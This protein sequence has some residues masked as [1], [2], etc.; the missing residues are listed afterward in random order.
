MNKTNGKFVISLDFELMWGMKDVTTLAAYGDCIKGVHTALPHLLTMF[1]EFEIRATFSTVGFLFFDDKKSLLENL[2]TILPQYDKEFLSPYGK[3]M[4]TVGENGSEDS[5]HFGKYLIEEIKKHPEQ[6]IGTH[7]FSHYY[8]LERGQSAEAFKADLAKAMEVG[9]KNGIKIQSLVFPK[10]QFNEEYLKICA[11][12]GIAC[13]RGNESSWLYAAADG[14]AKNNLLKRALRLI[15]AYINLSGHHCY[16]GE[17]LQKNRPMNIPSSRFLR[18][19]SKKLAFLDILKLQR[20][21]NS[22]THAAKNGLLYHLWWHPHNF[23][24]HQSENFAFLAKILQHYQFLH[25][26]YGFQSLTMIETAGFLSEYD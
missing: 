4:S 6:E 2:P 11:D 13:Y 19:F 22:M 3:Y 7:T 26:K 12:L 24:I 21:K 16:S 14:K 17:Y 8:C 25:Q 18:P 15:D 10:N 5:Y 9:E 1:R 20:I 23:G